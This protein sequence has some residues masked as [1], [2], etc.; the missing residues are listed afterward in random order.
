MAG[1]GSSASARPSVVRS[2]QKARSK[3]LPVASRIGF[4]T[5]SVAPRR[6]VERN[7]TSDPP[8]MCSP[9]CFVTRSTCPYAASGSRRAACRRSRH[10]RRTPRPRGSS[11]TKRRRPFSK[12]PADH[13]V[14]VGFVEVGMTAL[15]RLENLRID[16]DS[17]RRSKPFSAIATASVRPTYPIPMMQTRLSSYMR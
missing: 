6:T 11:R 14:E 13:V 1:P 10:R 2:G 9:T 17:V 8:A 12:V 4:A 3:S 15:D 7:T 16:L 5:L